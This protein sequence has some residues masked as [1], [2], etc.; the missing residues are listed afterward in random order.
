MKCKK[1]ERMVLRSIEGHLSDEEMT[2]L[3]EHIRSC[4]ACQIKREEYQGILD[5]LKEEEFPEPKPYFWERLQFK[6]NERR[7]YEPLS[8]WKHWGLRA[9]PISLLIV[10]LLAA[11]ILLFMPPKEE[12]LAPALSQS[13]ILLF[14]NTNPLQETQTIL[15]QEGAENKSM[16]LIFTSLAEKNGV[17][18]QFP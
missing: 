12:E 8:L 15:E 17:R 13:G 1:A 16:M 2:I 4:P 10:V 7:R 18:R 5:A 3:E 9:I 11:V 6:L 14:Q